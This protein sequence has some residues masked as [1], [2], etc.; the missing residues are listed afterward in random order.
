M[1]IKDVLAALEIVPA[2]YKIANKVMELQEMHVP[3]MVRAPFQ[4]VFEWLLA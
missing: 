1:A 2:I 3:D 4:P